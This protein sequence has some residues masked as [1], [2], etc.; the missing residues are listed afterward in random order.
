M[1]NQ[2]GFLKGTSGQ[3]E[4]SRALWNQNGRE[5]HQKCDDIAQNWGAKPHWL[6]FI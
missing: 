5:E 1:T 3:I 2:S 6:F 4:K